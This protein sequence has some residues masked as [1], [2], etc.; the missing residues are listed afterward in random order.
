MFGSRGA[1]MAG[2]RRVGAQTC[3]CEDSGFGRF[4]PDCP[5]L[6]KLSPSLCDMLELVCHYRDQV[7]GL[8]DGDDSSFRTTGSALVGAKQRREDALRQVKDILETVSRDLWKCFHIAGSKHPYTAPALRE[9]QQWFR[10]Q[11]LLPVLGV[12][13][14]VK[15]DSEARDVRIIAVDDMSLF[16][17]FR[18]ELTALSDVGDERDEDEDAMRVCWVDG[19]PPSA[20]D[21]SSYVGEPASEEYA[22]EV[23]DYSLAGIEAD[24]RD[25][26]ALPPSPFTVATGIIPQK[27]FFAPK[28]CLTLFRFLGVP[29]LSE[30]ISVRWAVGD[31]VPDPT[32]FCRLT[33]HLLLGLQYYFL[34]KRPD[35]LQRLAD[36]AGGKL[37]KLLRLTVRGCFDI[38][39]STTLNLPP[40]CGECVKVQTDQMHH[41]D[42]AN[43]V[44]FVNPRIAPKEHAKLRIGLVM[45]AL[46]IDVALLEQNKSLDL[47]REVE[48]LLE[49]LVRSDDDKSVS[50]TVGLFA[51]AL[52][53]LL[54]FCPCTD[55][56][57]PE[58]RVQHAT[59][60]R[61]SAL[62]IAR[63]CT[64]NYCRGHRSDSGNTRH[65]GR[66]CR[67]GGRSG[68]A[69]EPEEAGGQPAQEEGL[70]WRCRDGGRLARWSGQ[71]QAAQ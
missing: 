56:E 53:L 70:R 31:S 15:A 3:Y 19:L 1:P 59:A 44:L 2:D 38:T 10:F 43:D 47:L 21:L 14:F 36:F 29:R 61:R 17:A 39:R 28:N 51:H 41:H 8:A 49:K 12:Y 63:H 58:L 13:E 33:N 48:Q 6:T 27:T 37:Q 54:I 71:D 60:T 30:F 11:E 42:A 20:G 67:E 45:A 32:G 16:E 34:N 23:A 57:L 7:L 50:L 62:A 40:H 64:R 46:R 66:V 24:M 65:D 52:V 25:M 69:A 9:M 22:D 4:L 68:D 18:A 35:L 55:R 26:L 5:G